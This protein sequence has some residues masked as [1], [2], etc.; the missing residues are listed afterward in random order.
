MDEA[1]GEIYGGAAVSET[2]ILC[3]RMMKMQ[4]SG[5]MREQ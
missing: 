3:E 1:E 5:E 2:M 4:W